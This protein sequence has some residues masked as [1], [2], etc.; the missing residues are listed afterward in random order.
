M[1]SSDIFKIKKLAQT[2]MSI[3]FQMLQGVQIKFE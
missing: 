1:I 2:I 3:H